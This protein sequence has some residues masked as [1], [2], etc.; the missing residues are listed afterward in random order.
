MHKPE[1]TGTLLST[2]AIGRS[3]ARARV[4][5][6]ALGAA[7][8]LACPAQARLLVDLVQI[9]IP[10]RDARQ[11]AVRPGAWMP[12]V[13]DI[14]LE[15]EPSFDGALRAVQRDG[16]GDQIVDTVEV[17]LLASA[18]GTQRYWLYTLAGDATLGA[19]DDFGIEV[20]NADGEV[21][22]VVSAG[23][24]KRRIVPEEPPMIVQDNSSTNTA[25][26]LAISV[27][28]GGR[29]LDLG[30]DSA[31]FDRQFKVGHIAPATIPNLWIGLEAVDYVV[32]DE[33][34]P[35]D[36]SAKQLAA[37]MEWVRQGGT[38]LMAAS[39]TA[40]AV[41]GHA[42]LAAALPVEIGEVVRMT[43]P[44]DLIARHL[45]DNE[46]APAFTGAMSV[47]RCTARPGA[48]VYYRDD[49]L[50]T[51]LISRARLGRG[52]VIFS[53]ASLVDLFTKFSP[54]VV[55]VEDP[56]D[57]RK[58]RERTT[59]TDDSVRDFYRRIF[60][61][62]F[63]DDPNDQ[64]NTSNHF[65]LEHV[66]GPVQFP[67]DAGLY[68][69]I[70]IMFMG[71]YWCIATLGSWAFLQRRGWQR[72][73]WTAFTCVAIVAAFLSLSTVQAVQG[74]GITVRQV[75]VVDA[76]VGERFGH[77]T[78]FFGMKTAS[79]VDMDVWLPADPVADRQPAATNCYLRPVLG[80]ASDET[81]PQKSQYTD[82]G[83][84]QLR[85][86]NAELAGVPFRATMKALEGR[87]EGPL[88]GRVTGRVE[89][90]RGAV[91]TRDIR[92]TSGSFITNELGVDLKKCYLLC[93]TRE[94]YDRQTGEVL[95]QRGRSNF[96]V[97]AIPLLD[98]KASETVLLSARF[99][100][101]ARFP[102]D[103]K[104]AN[105]FL[106]S[107]LLEQEQI[108]WLNSTVSLL[109][110]R[111]VAGE[112]DMRLTTQESGLLLVST[113]GDFDPDSHRQTSV[114]S[115]TGM[116]SNGLQRGRLRHLDLRDQ[117]RP[118]M[119]VLVGFG[120]DHPGPIRLASRRGAREY[121]L[122]EPDA[123]AS[124]T[125]YRIRIPVTGRSS[126]TAPIEPEPE[127][128]PNPPQEAPGD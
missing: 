22:E 64:P 8:A 43:N 128:E 91:G 10:T 117:L 9:G 13:V 75:S 38:L 18:G 62:K 82:P 21:V 26:V 16:D 74:F 7:V 126:G 102:G 51:D 58:R 19:R 17:H 50:K 68:L 119:A 1:G 25:I 111:R 86:A 125:M 96:S 77:G 85:P 114:Y 99:D 95:G 30:T 97:L 103:A 98:I 73:N 100:P 80:D 28:S 55:E 90:T 101:D 20:L 69:L 79:H 37:V 120:E 72:H 123:A 53:A 108:R 40:G 35:A 54:R 121:R 87:W 118:D 112:I 46:N 27:A 29:A 48:F 63:Y 92:F 60:W 115:M 47:A 124:I 39:N 2:S 127:T 83:S 109:G 4:A 76:D 84:Y 33:A 41:A 61:Q 94:L 81:A 32:W 44:G 3:P 15:G 23:E 57:R 88:G 89:F 5:I 36:M 49:A 52:H 107:Y 70:T 93:T 106:E 6:I 110:K 56:D 31:G 34:D 59:V 113:M 42:E 122:E 67:E 65:V 11:G 104:K 71:V 14:T 45:F 12:V 24:L 105:E 78:A 116:D 66:R